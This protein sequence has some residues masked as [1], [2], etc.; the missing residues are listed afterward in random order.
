MITSPFSYFQSLSP[1]LPMPQTALL[2]CPIKP[3]S[4]FPSGKYFWDFFSCLL[5]WRTHK[6]FLCCKLPYLRVWL[7]VGFPSGSVVKNLPAMKEKEET[8][9]IPELGRTPGKGNGNPLQY[10]CWE[11]PI[12]RGAWRAVVRGIAKSQT[13]LRMQAHMCR[14][15]RANDPVR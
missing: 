12:D 1:T 7:A 15:E 13:Q 3:P 11:S 10:P 14:T 8:C 2:P 4:P 9:L 5:A 6:T